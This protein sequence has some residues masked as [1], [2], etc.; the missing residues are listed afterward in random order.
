[1]TLDL[2]EHI[3]FPATGRIYRSQ[4]R[5]LLAD[6]GPDGS[7]RLDAIARYLHD[8]ATLDVDDAGLTSNFLWILR[9]TTTT[10]T[11]RPTYLQQISIETSCSGYGK[12]WAERRSRVFQGSDLCIDASAIWVNIDSIGGRPRSLDRSFASVYDPSA[13]G[14]HVSARTLL[15]P[16]AREPEH[17]FHYA[18]RVTD[19]DI[20]GHVNNA[21]HSS[22]VEQALYDMGIESTKELAATRI[23][24]G[25]ALEYGSPIQ[26]SVWR[27]EQELFFTLS[28]Q[29]RV[30]SQLLALRR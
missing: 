28:Q 21:V 12:A 27:S 16:P 11:Q 1:V 22:F 14:R 26:V 8:V 13:Q 19:L 17:R 23:E 7:V 18:V 4:E 20:M 9:S 30:R 2:F 6:T 5:V 10:I 29:D 15:R 24:F 3:D 25:Q